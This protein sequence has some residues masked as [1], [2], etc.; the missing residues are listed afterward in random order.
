MVL[1]IQVRRRRRS[2]SAPLP[3]AGFTPTPLQLCDPRCPQE[4]DAARSATSANNSGSSGAFTAALWPRGGSA[5]GGAPPRGG[6]SSAADMLRGAATSEPSHSA[7]ASLEVH[8]PPPAS[9]LDARR[10]SV[11]FEDECR[12]APPPAEASPFSGF[13]RAA[14]GWG[15]VEGYSPPLGAAVSAFSAPQRSLDAAASAA[16]A[17]LAAVDAARPASA[18]AGPR[19]S[20]DSAGS[21]GSGRRTGLSVAQ[22]LAQMQAAEAAEAPAAAPTAALGLAGAR[23]SP[24]ALA[25]AAAARGGGSASSSQRTSLQEDEQE[26]GAVLAGPEL[27]AFLQDAFGAHLAPPRAAAAASGGG[28]SAGK[29]PSRGSLEILLG[30]PSPGSSSRHSLDSLQELLDAGHRCGHAGALAGLRSAGNVAALLRGS[31]Y[32][33]SRQSLDPESMGLDRRSVAGGGKG[34]GKGSMGDLGGAGGGAVAAAVA[35]P[36]AGGAAGGGGVSASACASSVV[37]RYS[38]GSTPPRPSTLLPEAPPP[39]MMD[40]DVHDT[41]GAHVWYAGPSLGLGTAPPPN[42]AAAATQAH[43]QAQAQ[44]ALRPASSPPAASPRAAAGAAGAPP[45]PPPAVPVGGTAA[46]ATAKLLEPTAVHGQHSVTL[47]DAQCTVPS[48]DFL[49]QRQ[50]ARARQAS[51]GAATW[52][53]GYIAE[54]KRVLSEAM[55]QASK[56]E[57]D[58]CDTRWAV[59]AACAF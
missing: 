25:A 38:P 48:Y 53:G 21:G 26:V 41:F 57:A 59:A 27:A 20:T 37:D 44:A 24:A 22:H 18:A 12:P 2:L 45:P 11:S 51:E 14:P 46:Q 58:I 13:S 28:S 5:L 9:Q 16:M 6:G 42:A 29:P 35:R 32:T 23:S 47:H 3:T 36:A 43:A 4:Q 30:T 10:K 1:V 40:A 55:S 31:G 39:A 19:R 33:A 52:G 49:R 34:G 17:A 56:D 54:A 8:H 15:G 7:R 50:L